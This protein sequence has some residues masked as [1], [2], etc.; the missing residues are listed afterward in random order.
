MLAA[1]PAQFPERFIAPYITTWVE[2][3]QTHA[4]EVLTLVRINNAFRDESGRPNAAFNARADEVVTVPDLTWATVYRSWPSPLGSRLNVGSH[5]QAQRRRRAAGP[6]TGRRAG[7]RRR[8]RC[9]S[10]LR[11]FARAAMK[12]A[13]ATPETISGIV[14]GYVP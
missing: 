12:P 9:R 13:Q 4:K 2:Y 14:T 11:Q 10:R 3:Y 7:R 8:R 1:G 6:F 5:C